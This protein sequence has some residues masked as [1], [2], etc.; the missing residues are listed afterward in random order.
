MDTNA[1]VTPPKAPETPLEV[2]VSSEKGLRE[3]NQDWLSWTETPRGELFI[4]ADGMG[5]YKGGARA[6][7]MTVDLVEKYL[8]EAPADMPFGKALDDAVRRTNV[9]VHQAAHNG[10]PDTENMGSTLVVALVS[11]GKVQVGHVGD[12]RAYLFGKGRLRRLTRDHTRVQQM[13][14]AEMITR[15]QARNHPES[16]VLSRAIG[17][18]PEVEMDVS[19]P[20][21]LEEGDALLLCSDGLSGFVQDS[22][23][24]KV[25][26]QQ[27]DAQQV[28]GDLVS[29]ALAA[30]SND[31][32]TVQYVRFGKTI[33]ERTTTR[34][35]IPPQPIAG[36]PVWTVLAGYSQRP[37]VWA[38][39]VGV[40]VAA[41]A[42]PLLA[43]RPPALAFASKVEGA[44]VVLTWKAEAADSLDIQPPI[45]SGPLPLEGS[46]RVPLPV[47]SPLTYKATATRKR[48]MIWART[49]EES[50]TIKPEVSAGSVPPDATVTVTPV[51]PPAPPAPAS[52][53]TAGSA[54]RPPNGTQAKPAEAKDKPASNGR[55]GR[56]GRSS[57]NGTASKSATPTPAGDATPAPEPPADPPPP[58]PRP[59]A[60]GNPSTEKEQAPA[61]DETQT[62]AEGERD[63]R[64]GAPDGDKPPQDRG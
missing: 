61:R 10:D 8:K 57:A 45:D 53:E 29:V 64:G 33:R 9:E 60:D 54:S 49:S 34:L 37:A 15:K 28:A 19:P 51:Q 4:V 52:E 20:H 41:A 5:G 50:L 43:L 11:D 22:K 36:A 24:R 63:G 40:L 31:N 3:E 26:E 62:P 48:F 23:I 35:P 38:T 58:T 46:A 13:I 25:L 1:P 17:S 18:R 16:H 39:I 59:P 42:I 32:I 21:K 7:K 12:S 47:T 44:Q 14:D 27:K 30:G 56:G 6:A 2:A 55:T